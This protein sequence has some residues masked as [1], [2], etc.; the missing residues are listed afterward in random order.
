MSDHRWNDL[1]A[2]KLTLAQREAN[3]RWVEQ[4]ILEMNLRALRE[5]LGKTQEELAQLAETAQSELSRTERR[6]DHLVST[7]RRYVEA[8]GGELEV[9]ASFGKK[10]IRLQGV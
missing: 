7:L 2:S 4:E 10:S 5:F 3:K 6:D 1:K 9:V 8:L